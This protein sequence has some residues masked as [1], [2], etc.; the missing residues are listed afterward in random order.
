MAKKLEA[1]CKKLLTKF[2]EEPDYTVDSLTWDS[3]L[4]AK[5]KTVQVGV[6][7]CA[8]WFVGSRHRGVVGAG[9]RSRWH[10]KLWVQQWN[11]EESLQRFSVGHA[12]GHMSA[13]T[14]PLPVIDS[15]FVCVSK[16]TGPPKNKSWMNH[17]R[18]PQRE[19][20]RLLLARMDS[21]SRFLKN[22]RFFPP[23]TPCGGKSLLFPP[24]K[25]VLRGALQSGEP[26]ER[27]VLPWL[28]GSERQT[29]W[30]KPRRSCP[31]LGRS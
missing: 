1:S 17:L 24:K 19:L 9:R 22:P 27:C 14:V 28:V 26:V 4:K 25:P 13:H 30:R 7:A 23:N 2:E 15:I 31:G 12:A 11:G 8:R 3:S 5:R 29:L 20:E 16:K 21:R 6:E 18:V 10:R